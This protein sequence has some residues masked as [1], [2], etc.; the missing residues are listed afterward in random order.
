MCVLAYFLFE[1]LILMFWGILPINSYPN[2]ESEKNMS[3]SDLMGPESIA[4]NESITASA[5]IY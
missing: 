3:M 2:N 1:F 4:E 5:C